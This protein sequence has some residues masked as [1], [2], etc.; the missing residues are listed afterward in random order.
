ME[1]RERRQ[2]DQG[3]GVM[4]DPAQTAL[5]E[6][7]KL[8]SELADR[9][10]QRCEGANRLYVSVL[11][12]MVTFLAVAMRFGVGSL[13]SDVML[14]VAGSFGALLSLS[15]FVVLCSYRQLNSGKFKALHELETQ[16]AYPFFTTE[17]RFL[18][19]GRNRYWKLTVVETGLPWVFFALFIAL[20]VLSFIVAG[21]SVIECP[22]SCG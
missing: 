1:H 12:G 20:T 18:A 5:L 21:D 14:G 13:P 11:A 2:R 15:W 19:E 16:L 4:A 8:H 17:W 3:I 7:Y 9:V 6:I 10:S 22:S